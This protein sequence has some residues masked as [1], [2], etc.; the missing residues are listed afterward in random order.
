MIETKQ[1]NDISDIIKEAD[2]LVT[3]LNRTTQKDKRTK[4]TD[5]EN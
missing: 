2:E 3:R 4:K 5:A 1:W